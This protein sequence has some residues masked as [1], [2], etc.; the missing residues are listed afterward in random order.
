MCLTLFFTGLEIVTVTLD[1]FTTSN[2]KSYVWSGWRINRTFM[3]S[4]LP[5]LVSTCN[6]VPLFF[7]LNSVSYIITHLLARANAFTSWPN[8]LHIP[9]DLC[10]SNS[11]WK[12]QGV[13]SHRVKAKWKGNSVSPNPGEI[14]KVC[15]PL[16]CFVLLPHVIMDLEFWM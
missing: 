12:I 6:D 16:L 7:F 3:K 4:L 5:G 11:L 10:Y 15:G 14:I 9:R 8:T 2:K 13:A 1:H